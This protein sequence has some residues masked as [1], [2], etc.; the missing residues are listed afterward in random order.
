M[1]NRISKC[2]A[3]SGM[4]LCVISAT[5]QESGSPSSERNVVTTKWKEVLRTTANHVLQVDSSEA[6]PGRS[7]GLMEQRGRILQDGDVGTLAAWLTYEDHDGSVSYKGYVRYR[8][9]DGATMFGALTGDGQAPGDQQGTISLV[10][11][12]GRFKGIQGT[13]EFTAA[14]PS[15]IVL[16]GRYIVDV[17]G[18]YSLP[19]H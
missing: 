4:C 1:A 10:D 7:I 5:A 12:T 19:L 6:K 8:F 16:D 13:L 18:Q 3:I 15:P 14:S 11:G 9:S 17:A 2:L